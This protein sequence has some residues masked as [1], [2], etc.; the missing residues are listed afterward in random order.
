MY[1]SLASAQRRVDR[2][3]TNSTQAST[4][5][6]EIEQTTVKVAGGF[7][8]IVYTPAQLTW[9][10][11]SEV[12]A[13]AAISG[14][15]AE[16]I[17][18]DQLN[19][20]I[21]AAVGAIGN[22][23]GL[24][25]DVSATLGVSYSAINRSHALFGDRSGALVAQIM[26]GATYHK[27]IGENITNANRL[28]QAGGVTVVDILGKAVVVTDS[29]ALSST[30]TPNKGFVLSLASGGITVRDTADLVTNIVTTNGK[31]I[32]ETSFQ[33][34]YSFGL[35]VR[36]FTWDTTNGGKSPS[37]EDIAT[38]TNWDMYV[39]SPKDTAGVLLAF[40]SDR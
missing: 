11:T 5:L 17:I 22:V 38:G 35:G 40:D 29:P 28:Y 20:G 21:A 13:I 32:I 34:D 39:T 26:N 8:P 36:G 25:V 31:Q 16:F 24:S 23:A 14:A 19:S 18:Q 6:R 30:G 33:S 4:A 15:L 7:G 2:Y 1:A 3:A 12:E 10:Q 37:S 9:M 27:L